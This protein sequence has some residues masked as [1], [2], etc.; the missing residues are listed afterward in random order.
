M[1]PITSALSKCVVE[2]R[3]K[4][5]RNHLLTIPFFEQYG[6]AFGQVNSPPPSLEIWAVNEDV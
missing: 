6:W 3:K 4:M 2:A 5:G 1:S